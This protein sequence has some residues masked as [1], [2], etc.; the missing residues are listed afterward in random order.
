LQ[1]KAGKPAG[2]ILLTAKSEEYGESVIECDAI[3]KADCR[4]AVNYRYLKDL[5]SLCR[6]SRITVKVKDPSSP[7]V[8]EIASNTCVIMPM[9]VYQW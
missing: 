9:H 8:F 5:L 6:D 3:V 2:K 7:M 4:I 1:F